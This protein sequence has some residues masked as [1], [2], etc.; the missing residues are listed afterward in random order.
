MQ[1]GKIY[2]TIH[3]APGYMS[4]K[5]Y[6]GKEHV[7]WSVYPPASW[8]QS[9]GESHSVSFNLGCDRIFLDIAAFGSLMPLHVP[10]HPYT[11]SNPNKLTSVLSKTWMKSQFWS[12]AVVL[13]G[14]NRHLFR[15]SRKSHTVVPHSQILQ[16]PCRDFCMNITPKE[17]N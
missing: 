13:F 3:R 17:R 5:D 9:S 10:P 15:P 4:S 16:R 1:K 7:L 2:C 11:I 8:S 14:V 6:W 12:V